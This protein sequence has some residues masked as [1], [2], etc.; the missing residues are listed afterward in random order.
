VTSNSK[1]GTGKENDVRKIKISQGYEV[2]RTYRRAMKIH[3]KWISFP[4]DFWG[5]M[6]L[7]AKNTEEMI[8]IQVTFGAKWNV[9]A[10]EILLQKW[11]K[12]SKVQIWAW[13]GGRKRKKK[14][15]EGLIKAQCYDI[16]ELNHDTLQ[17]ELKMTVDAKGVPMKVEK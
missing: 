13:F 8:F 17:F 12:W 2:Q 1:K 4:N 7:E 9:K 16:Y 10:A 6:D 11:P 3:G 14:I 15:G 5:C